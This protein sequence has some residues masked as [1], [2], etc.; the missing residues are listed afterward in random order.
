MHPRCL[1]CGTPDVDVESEGEHVV[2]WRCLH[3]GTVITIQRPP[4]RH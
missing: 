1:H 3:C 2:I 4:N